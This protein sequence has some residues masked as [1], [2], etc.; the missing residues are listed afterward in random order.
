MTP[1]QWYEKTPEGALRC[2]L[3]P[4]GC[5]VPE[6]GAGRCGA[7]VRRGDALWAESYGQAAALALDPIEKKP[8]RRFYPGA[9]IL[10]YGS[11]G[12]NLRC[13]FCQNHSISLERPPT[14]PITPEALAAQAAALAAQGNLGVAYT[15][16]EPL[17]AYEF[18]LDTARRV[19]ARGLKNVVVTNGY[20]NPAPLETLLPHIDAWNIDLKGF[21]EDFYRQLGGGLAPVQAAIRQAAARCHVEL[22][23]L[24]LPEAPGAP[25]NG[26][27]AALEALAQWVAEVDPA[28]PLH[29]TCFYPRW[30]L[31][32]L[33]PTAPEAVEK[34]GRLARKFLRYVYVAGELV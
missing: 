15:Y 4:H 6:G 2:L 1:A 13:P 20:V 27:P 32:G 26:D 21:S 31:R 33:P 25:R 19:R 30:K 22:T 8:L 11:Y 7:R 9:K 16:N 12:C 23:T 14:E 17:V 29:L 3:C 5:Q 28:I 10:S 34:L 18:L 24:V